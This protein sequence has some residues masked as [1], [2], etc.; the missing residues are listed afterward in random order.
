M[1]GNIGWSNRRSGL[2]GGA[3]IYYLSTDKHSYT[4]RDFLQGLGKPLADR[5]RIVAY[6]DFLKAERLPSKATYV[7]SD[8][9]RLSGSQSLTV[10][11]RWKRLQEA[12]AK[13]VNHPIRAM[14][15]Y[16]LLRWAHEA[17]INAFDTYMV[18]EHR[19]PKR[20]PVFIRRAYDHEGAIS[21]L[22]H[23]QEELDKALASMRA[24]HEWPGDKMITE[25]LD[26]SNEDGVFVKYAAFRV[27]DTLI[28]RQIMAAKQWV[29]KKPEFD[30]PE[31]AAQEA[32]YLRANPHGDLLM[33]I[34]KS[35]H[36][37]YGRIDYCVVD[38]RVQV[39]EINSNPSII[40]AASTEQVLNPNSLRGPAYRA[41][42]E[43]YI[44]AFATLDFGSSGNGPGAAS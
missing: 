27:G 42:I 26:V 18:I 7:F 22:I 19:K 16:D 8:I 37:D 36:I 12:G 9:D 29:V 10:F 38:G 14:R 41:V 25:Y 40:G 30:S 6:G 20:F 11:E 5:V 1:T 35:A 28:P 3:L 15:R 13:L 32:A 2:G 4:M 31:L 39:F 44:E 24:A 34:F 23:S 43:K 17:G 33:H 21:P